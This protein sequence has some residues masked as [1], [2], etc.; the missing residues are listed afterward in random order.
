MVPR[1]VWV[2]FLKI[3]LAVGLLLFARG[4][5]PPTVHQSGYN[6]VGHGV[7]PKFDKIVFMVVD[8]MRSDFMFSSNS[9][10]PQVHNLIRSGFCYPFT[11]YS[12]PPTVT[13]PRLKGLTTGSSPNFLDAVINVA[14]DDS[15]SS[16]TTHDSWI[17]QMAL[18]NKTLHMFGDDTW[19]KLFP[20]VFDVSDG[21]SSFYVSDYTEVD[22]NVTRHLATEFSERKWDGLILHYLGMDHIGH[23]SGPNNNLMTQKQ[24]E[25]DGII[26]RIFNDMDDNTLLVVAGDHGM[27]DV[28]NHGGA[29]KGETSAALALFSKTFENSQNAPLPN[30]PDYSYYNDVAQVDLVTTLSYLLGFPVPLNS[31]GLFIPELAELYS[32]KDQEKILESQCIKFGISIQDCSLDT[33][34]SQ[35]KELVKMTTAYNFPYMY[36]GLLILGLVSVISLFLTWKWLPHNS[37]LI[38]WTLVPIVYFIGMLGSSTVE[39]EHFIWYWLL[40]SYLIFL[41]CRSNNGNTRIMI[42][43]VLACFRLIRGYKSAGQKWVAMYDVSTFFSNHPYILWIFITF[44]FV[45]FAQPSSLRMVASISV[46][47]YKFLT[48][49]YPISLP[50]MVKYARV[51]FVLCILD[52]VLSKANPD[53]L[54]IMLSKNVNIPMWPVILFTKGLINC[55]NLSV[56]YSELLI[57]MFGYACF[58]ALGGS[59]SIA[60]IDLS[61]AYHGVSNYNIPLVSTLTYLSNWSHSLI[62]INFS[63]RVNLSSKYNGMGI[64]KTYFYSISCLSVCI[65]CWVLREHLFIWTVFAPKLLYTGAWL[66]VHEIFARYIGDL[67]CQIMSYFS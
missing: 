62:W 58:F 4:F 5:L 37:A 34:K 26:G 22:F 17:Q 24:G 25:M 33:L 7:T 2:Y 19:L 65:A 59:N 20:N 50:R 36:T 47:V 1:N 16:I 56:E 55:L 46:F 14:D 15:S 35:Q 52:S 44:T 9:N 43:G 54:F 27:N 21:T 51:C 30:D 31:L 64:A 28:G 3:T 53:L 11:A 60:T 48:T 38:W 61:N 67:I 6:E 23:K 57:L 49:I 32:K 63:L 13:L 12:D 29:S 41:F 39:E 40:T 45:T 66:I 8:A 10:M 42:A 18:H